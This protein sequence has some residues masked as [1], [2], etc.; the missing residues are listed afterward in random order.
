MKHPQKQLPPTSSEGFWVWAA[1]VDRPLQQVLGGEAAV[2]CTAA[3]VQ[4]QMDW[5][6]GTRRLTFLTFPGEDSTAQKH[7][8]RH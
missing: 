7:G 3:G 8:Q 2:A 4:R 1:L 6:R 5:R